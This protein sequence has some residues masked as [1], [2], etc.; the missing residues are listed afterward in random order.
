MLSLP[1]AEDVKAAE[2]LL[3]DRAEKLGLNIRAYHSYAYTVARGTPTLYLRSFVPYRDEYVTD[4]K[5]T[6][7]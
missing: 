6:K 2:A 3:K 7:E 4:L 5:G 1:S